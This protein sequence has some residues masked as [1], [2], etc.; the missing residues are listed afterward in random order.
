[1][2]VQI[3]HFGKRWIEQKGER[4]LQE[5]IY[6]NKVRKLE[7]DGYNRKNRKKIIREN[8]QAKRENRV[9][10]M[11]TNEDEIEERVCRG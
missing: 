1:M 10:K 11:E 9:R 6:E 7:R 3:L 8:I 5:K 4:E 2:G